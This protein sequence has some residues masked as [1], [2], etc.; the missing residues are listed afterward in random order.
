MNHSFNV[1]I[2]QKE[3]IT[4]VENA[5]NANNNTENTE[6]IQDTNSKS[7]D[8][9]KTGLV[10]ITNDMQLTNTHAF[11]ETLDQIPK[12]VD[13][14]DKLLLN[15]RNNPS[16]FVQTVDEADLNDD[17]KEI[18]RIV[19]FSA[20]INNT[21]KDIK[22]Y[23]NKHRDMVVAELDRRLNEAGFDKLT[24]GHTDIKQLK[25]DMKNQRISD[26]W[27][28]LKPVFTGSIQHYPLF[29]ELAP[30]LLDFSKFRLIHDK[31]VSGA[32]AKNITDTIKRQ[33]VETVANWNTGLE[34]IKGNQWGLSSQKLFDLLKSFKSNPSI[35]LVMTKGPQLKTQQD[36]EL[37]AQEQERIR[38][39]K[40]EQ[41]A[42]EAKL[43]REQ[44]E[45][46]L[47][48]Q[49]EKMAKEQDAKKRLEEEQKAKELEQ[50]AAKARQ[51]ELARQ[52]ELEETITQHVP[53]LV[54]QSFPNVVEFLFSNPKLKS[55]HTNTNAKAG[56]I[57][58]LSQQLLDKESPVY[59]DTQG[60]AEKYIECIRF[61]LDA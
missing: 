45:A 15:Y 21:R 61:V 36:A 33:V 50:K 9:L 12:Y 26:R 30:E 1:Y 16:E 60:D 51:D 42:K 28:E 5:E 17:L 43:K 48:E 27:D 46:A 57:Y 25:A 53:P 59:K 4:M 37:Q 54:R 39:E 49:Q 47:K 40:A 56:A 10:E 20:E 24:T 2:I 41:D 6:P 55:L 13:R 29:E 3:G 18:N 52:K 11:Q 38:R 32:K 23:Y 58:A 44:Q 34:L 35:D 7:A 19:S 8:T 31:L 14:V 22:S